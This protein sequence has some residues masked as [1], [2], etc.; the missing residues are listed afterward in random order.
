MASYRV[1]IVEDEWLIAR[2]YVSILGAA[3]HVPV[4]P[5]AS[6]IAAE[7]LLDNE[8]VDIA[9]LDYK[10]GAGTS[11]TLVQRLNQAGIPFIVSTGH[12]K[13]DLPEEF[14]SGALV[15]KPADP[16]NLAATIERLL[17][18]RHT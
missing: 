2:D 5:A 15:A 8:Q 7:A 13:A 10:L 17:Q 11:A 9:L 14:S 16:R 3:G 12:A 1:L 6:V 4:G 18:A